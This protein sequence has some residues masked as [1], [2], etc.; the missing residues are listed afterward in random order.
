MYPCK[1]FIRSSVP[2]CTMLY[3]TNNNLNLNSGMKAFLLLTVIEFLC[4]TAVCLIKL[5]PKTQ[6]SGLI[7]L[8]KVFLKGIL[9]IMN[10]NVFTTFKKSV[11]EALEKFIAQ[12]G[13]IHINILL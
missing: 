4:I 10:M 2:L 13:K 7:G 8:K 6:M 5:K 1:S 3:V 11:M 12:T 9:N